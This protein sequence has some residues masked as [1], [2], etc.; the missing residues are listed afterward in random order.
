MGIEVDQRHFAEPVDPGYSG[1]IGER[2]RVIPTEDDRDLPGPGDSFDRVGYSIERQ[3][4]LSRHHVHISD[5]DHAE[6]AQRRRCR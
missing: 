2:D 1:G 4:N 3:L 6:G 5:V